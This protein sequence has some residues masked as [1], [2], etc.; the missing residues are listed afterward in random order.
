MVSA[1]VYIAVARRN[2]CCIGSISFHTEVYWEKNSKHQ[3]RGHFSVFT[4]HSMLL[5][6]C[7]L[8]NSIMLF[9]K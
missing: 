9:C 8:G 5:Q 2:N 1:L 4:S 6:D 7:H 3:N